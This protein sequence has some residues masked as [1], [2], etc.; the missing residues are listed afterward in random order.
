MLQKDECFLAGLL[1]D[2]GMLALDKAPGEEYGQLQKSVASHGQLEAAEK[3]AFDLTHAKVSGL[4][5]REWKLP[6]LLAVPIECHHNP[7]SA[8]D[9]FSQ[10]MS[11]LVGAANR[12]ADVFIDQDTTP[13]IND[14]RSICQNQFGLSSAD[15]VELLAVIADQ[16]REQAPLFEI[17]IESEINLPA[18]L[19]EANQAL[20]DLMLRAEQQ[21][22]MLAAQNQELMAQVH[23]DVLTSLANRSRFEQFLAQQF[24]SATMPRSRW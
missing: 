16:A 6:P 23:R 10:S 21:A 24:R 14:V 22:K 18:I 11:A 12:I 2:I 3:N 9:A 1:C 17:T 8:P 19:A 5:A 13:A 4:L 20:V 7:S 15:C